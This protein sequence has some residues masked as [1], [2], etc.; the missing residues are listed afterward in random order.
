MFYRLE[1]GVLAG[2]E[3]FSAT[4][5]VNFSRG[6]LLVPSV[7]IGAS[8][9]GLSG[10][11]VAMSA[12]VFV[13][14]AI[15]AYLLKAKL[16]SLGVPLRFVRSADE[17]VF[18]TS[19]S[20]WMGSVLATGSIWV[21]T[22]LLSRHPDGLTQLGLFH[23]ADKW[24]LALIFLP[25]VMFQVILPMLSHSLAAGDLRT[26][27]RLSLAALSVIVGI[28]GSAAFVM[29]FF[30]GQLMGAFGSEFVAGSNVLP[31]AA[32]SGV[33]ASIN[34]VGSSILWALGHPTLMLRLDVFRTVLLI[35]L[36]VSG[37][38]DTAADAMLAYLISSA[39]GGA[40]VLYQVRKH[41]QPGGIA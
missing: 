7:Y 35:G 18:A 8:Y 11:I 12:V 3:A 33:T 31:L 10:A 26:C 4:A 6:L 22:V 34:T 14:C 40:T 15:G 32:A 25:Q 41:L 13:V 28:T 1:L 37:M 16:A 17:S 2:F 39:A 21:V 19:G 30:A 20:M 9:A 29:H 23:A 38:A 36:C 5:T 27:R 24:R